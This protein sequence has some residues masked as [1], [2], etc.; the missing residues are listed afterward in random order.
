MGSARIGAAL[1]DARF[2]RALLRG[3]GVIAFHDFQIIAAAVLDFLRETARPHRAY[4]L[5]D[6]VCVVELGSLPTLLNH[7]Q[8]RNQLVRPYWT[9]ANRVGADSLLVDLMICGAA[10]DSAP[11][12]QIG[13]PRARPASGGHEAPAGSS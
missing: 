5:K 12:G 4:W 9:A 6:V 13:V 10:G 11:H 2:C 7:P 8:V 3:T 1:R